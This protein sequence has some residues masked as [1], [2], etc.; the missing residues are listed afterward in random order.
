M[1]ITAV[2][3]MILISVTLPLVHKKRFQYPQ[4]E[5]C[6]EGVFRLLKNVTFMRKIKCLTDNTMA[7]AYRDKTESVECNKKR[8]EYLP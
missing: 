4:Q 6:G 7:E 1:N 3:T 5:A 2:N 8:I